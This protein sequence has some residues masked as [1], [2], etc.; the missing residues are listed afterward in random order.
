MFVFAVEYPFFHNR[1][2]GSLQNSKEF[3]DAFQCPNNSY[4]NPTNKCRY[5]YMTFK[6]FDCALLCLLQ[7]LLLSLP[8]MLYVPVNGD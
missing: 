8:C 6:S 2:Y 3:A 4:M 1:V 5:N 7:K